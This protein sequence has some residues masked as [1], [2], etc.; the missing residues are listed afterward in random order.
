MRSR[1]IKPGFFKDEKVL[2]CEPL[3][4]ILFG[5]L[6]CYAD[7]K[8]RFTWNPFE[9]KLEILPYDNCDI[10]NLLDQLHKKE[11]IYPYSINGKLYGYIPNFP[12][13]Q[14]PHVREK[15][16]EIP[17]PN[18]SKEQPRHDQGDA[19]ATP[20]CPDSLIPD[21]LI[22]DKEK[23]TG[24]PEAFSL[25]SQEIVKESSI[26]QAKK[27]LDKLCEEIYQQK[28]FPKVHAFKKQMLK[29]KKNPRAVIHALSRCYLK[30]PP[31]DQA[32]GYCIQVMKVEDGNYNEQDFRKDQGANN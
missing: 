1:N 21:S 3:A 16:S 4:R 11:L 24:K 20:R 26:P 22:P 14:R 23:S 12:K 25:P 17:H 10:D 27:E 29:E 7:R 30:R 15:E 6:W 18:C 2:K 28:L 13:H 8:G 19:K 32:W 9:I 5:G 31:P